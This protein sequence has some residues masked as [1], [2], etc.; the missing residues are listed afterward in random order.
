MLV[1][2]R[3]DAIEFKVECMQANVD[4]AISA[5]KRLE[6]AIAALGTTSSL[7]EK[8]CR[9][10]ESAARDAKDA[11]Q[12]KIEESEIEL[13]KI[14]LRLEGRGWLSAPPEPHPPKADSCGL[15]HALER[16]M[17]RLESELR[18]IKSIE[19][20]T[21]ANGGDLE[22]KVLGITKLIEE[23]LQQKRFEE[24]CEQTRAFGKG[25][26]GRCGSGKLPLATRKF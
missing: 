11:L 1:V 3:I 15:G 4:N 13:R 17:D 20:K 21:V 16:R 8:A 14:A 2:E 18:Q 19:R 22:D 5:I 24:K 9:R 10:I 7:E 23:H 26:L 25:K 6:A 12:R